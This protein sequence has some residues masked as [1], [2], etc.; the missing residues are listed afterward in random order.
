MELKYY[1]VDGDF[2]EEKQFKGIPEFEDKKGVQALK[3]VVVAYQANLRQGNACTKT[4]SEVSGTGKKPYR[5]KGT[6]MAR[7]GSKRSPIW[8]GGGVAFGPKPRDYSMDLNRKVKLLALKRAIFERAQ[9]K[10]LCVIEKWNVSD[11]K[12]GLVSSLLK[13]IT[14]GKDVLLVDDQFD[15]KFLLGIRNLNWAF[16]VDSS[17]VNA[18]DLIRYSTVVVSEN[19]LNTVLSRCISVN[20]E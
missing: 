2:K 14:S 19:A 8:R 1:N 16:T 13:K 5:Q 15:N 18:W 11:S 7:H 12:T 4:R 17:S 10:D 20:K 3:E 9:A 6:G